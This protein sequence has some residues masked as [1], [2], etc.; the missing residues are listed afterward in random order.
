ML[1]LQNNK[2]WQRY[3]NS[4]TSSTVTTRLDQSVFI[5]RLYLVDVSFRWH[6]LRI[7]CWD[8]LCYLFMH[9]FFLH[10]FNFFHWNFSFLFF[11][12]G[13]RNF[14][15][16]WQFRNILNSTMRCAQFSTIWVIHSEHKVTV[17]C[18]TKWSVIVWGFAG[19]VFSLI[20]LLLRSDQWR[21][22]W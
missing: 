14:C 15:L 10:I 1:G 6:M 19:L 12:F 13:Y 22:I 18:V 11:L 17:S 5:S 9:F 2:H 3:T 4:S 16:L 8:S 20:P 7:N 21:T